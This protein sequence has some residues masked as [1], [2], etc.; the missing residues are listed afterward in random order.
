MSR[1]AVGPGAAAGGRDQ[2]ANLKFIAGQAMVVFRVMACIGQ[3]RFQMHAFGGIEQQQRKMSLIGAQAGGR[4]GRQYQVRGGMH[5][6]GEL[7]QTLI[8]LGAAA[9][10]VVLLLLPGPLLFPCLAGGLP[11]PLLKM[12]AAMVPCLC[13]P[14]S[15][16]SHFLHQQIPRISSRHKHV[17][18]LDI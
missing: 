3:H 8:D 11:P 10:G 4:L 2:G 9:I 16:A 6:Q 14:M 13:G 1:G 17:Q 15:S 5:R 18:R 12:P 7:G